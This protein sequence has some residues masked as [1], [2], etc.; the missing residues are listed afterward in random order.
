MQLALVRDLGRPLRLDETP[1]AAVVEAVA[2]QLDIEPAVFALYARRDGT[3]REQAG[4][5]AA[6]LDLRSMRQADYRTSIRAAAVC[7]A[8]TDRGEPIACAVIED[9]KE[10][11]ITVP[12]PALVERLALAGRAWARRQ[13]HRD[14]A[15]G[16]DYAQRALLEALLTD[17]AED[18]RTLHGWIGEVR[19]GPNLK[20]LAGVT[21]RLE[22]LRRIRV[23]DE[24][25]RT[26]HANRYAI[27]AREARILPARALLRLAVERR[28]ATLAVFVIERQAV[29]TDLAVEMFDKLVGSARRTAERRHEENLLAQAEVLAAVAQDHAALGR[30][31]GWERLATSVDVAEGVAGGRAE[32]DGIEEMI[33]RRTTLRRAAAILFGSF[34]FRSHRADDPLLT[35]VGL[36]SE[37]YRGSRR[38][39]AGRVPTVFLRRAWR[40]RVKAGPDGLNPRAY[41]VAG[42]VHLRDRLRAGDIWV[43]GSRAYRRFEDYLLPPATFAALR[44]E[45][46]LGLGLPDTAAAWLEARGA[47]LRNKLKAVLAA[48]AAGSLVDAS[49]TEAGLK[50]APIRREQRDRAK[51]LSRRLYALVP[52]I[53][54]TDLLAEVNGWTGFA[55]RFTH[56]RTGEATADLPVLM[57]AILANATNLGLDR[58]AE[59]SRGL[60]IHQLNLV[61]DRYVRPETYAAALAAVVDAQHAQ[62]FAA[63]WGPGST[64]SSDGQFFP[65]GGRGEA[66]SDYNGRQGFEPGSV[67]YGFISDRFASYYSRVIAAA[68][69]GRKR[70]F[71]PLRARRADAP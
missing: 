31:L 4:E 13:S 5:I 32:G 36:L 14:L 57:G 46:R 15:R 19:E 48:A 56:F 1:P 2:D 43:E 58:M 3:R 24:R 41:E 29:L 40:S 70:R 18:G 16:L 49:L 65:A 50:V 64:S 52:R 35:A 9:L 27:L 38:K 55:E 62:P 42:I 20:N 45:D 39:L 33:G 26:V 7:A 54:I 69:S 59:S 61:I 66:T 34:R 60:T 21:A 51:V 8:G 10:R 63:V 12:P 25:R 53:R 28:L 47:V 37:L 17:R 44:A 23:D 30:A 68:A 67:F 22:V 11:R 71:R 6:L